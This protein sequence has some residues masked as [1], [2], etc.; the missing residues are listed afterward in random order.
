[1][2]PKVV[3]FYSKSENMKT[4]KHIFEISEQQNFTAFVNIE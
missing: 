2:E 4:F 1:M 3:L